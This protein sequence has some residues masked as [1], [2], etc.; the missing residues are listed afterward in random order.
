MEDSYTG[1]PTSH[2]LGSVPAVVDDG[3]SSTN[4]EVPEAN[5]QTFPPNS[6]G[7]RGRGYQSLA[8]PSG[9]SALVS[10]ASLAV[11]NIILYIRYSLGSHEKK[12]EKVDV[13]AFYVVFEV[14]GACNT[15]PVLG[16]YFSLTHASLVL[17]S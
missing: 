2:L 16:S 12:E 11:Y 3:K 15:T 8:G 13:T 5:M 1:L 7:D 6:G 17:S 14:H 9:S 10:L 4:Y